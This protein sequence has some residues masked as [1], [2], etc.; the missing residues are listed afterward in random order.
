MRTLYHFPHSPF[1]RRT[2]LALA[3]KGLACEL[4][5]AR[6]QP[7]FRDEARGL[8]A[9]RTIPVLVDGGRAMG[10][11]TAIVHWLDNAYP[12]A[13]RLWPNG[14]D[15]ADALQVA[16]LVDVV[17][18]GVVDVGTRYYALRGDAAW[19]GVKSEILGR[20]V[21]AAQALATRT[22]EVRRST[23]ASVGWSA[24]DMWLLTMTLWFEGL[25]ARAA[26][27]QLVAQ[28]LGLGF[29]LPAALSR[30]AD[31]HRDRGDVRALEPQA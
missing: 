16:A 24:A 29:E 11:S 19:D 13:P 5:D 18:N 27:N 4:R 22:A 1:S 8:V 14:D 23:I 26:T 3:H 17:L 15:A 7:A 6:E 25:P 12:G 10:D 21:R 31:A 20:A 28:V 2:R 9:F 30:W